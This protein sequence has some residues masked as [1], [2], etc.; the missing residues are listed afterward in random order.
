MGHVPEQRPYN[1][2][3]TPEEI[4]AIRERISVYRPPDLLMYA[5]MPVPSPFACR[6]FKEQFDVLTA[7]LPQYDLILDLT[8]AKVPDAVVREALKK[9]FGSQA[10]LRRAAVFTERNLLLN[11][12]ARYVLGSVGLR[13]ITVHRTLEE[14]LK[15]LAR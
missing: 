5:E 11:M 15:A 12:A 13:D 4:A 9:L 1:E 3:S 7:D 6:I 2:D 8:V 10:K 14:A